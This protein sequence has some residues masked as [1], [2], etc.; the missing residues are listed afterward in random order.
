MN[1]FKG[2]IVHIDPNGIMSLVQVQV[3]EDIFTSVV[4]DTPSTAGYLKV[5]SDVQIIVQETEVVL[6][7]DLSGSISMRNCFNALVKAVQRMQII[8][9]VI[10]DYQDQEI[11]SII[12]VGSTDRLD[13]NP[14]DT[15]QWLVKSNQVYL[16]RP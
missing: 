7:K 10:M 3:G 16:A 8:S 13:I 4:M 1:R 2:Q 11:I 15:V 12:T 6:A 9:R 14:G 5:D